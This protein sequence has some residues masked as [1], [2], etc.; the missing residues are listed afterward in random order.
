MESLENKPENKIL[1]EVRR[2]FLLTIFCLF[3][4]VFYG[5]IALLFLT[6]IFYSGWIT[7]LFNKYT[8]ENSTSGRIML[9]FM[10]SGFLLHGS[11]FTGTVMMWKLKKRG[12]FIFGISGLII[13]AYQLFQTR[14]SFITTLV[15]ILLILIF[16]LFYKKMR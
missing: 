13:A 12:Y 1:P 11:S 15:Y 9:L 10:T 6:G 3:A 2:P 4:F 8:P 5:L 16:G 14:I 7:E